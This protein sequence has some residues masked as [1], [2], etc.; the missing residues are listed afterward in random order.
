MRDKHDRIRY[1]DRLKKMIKVKGLQVAAIEVEDILLEHPD[2][3]LCDACVSGVNNG[4]G[5]GS[6]FVRAWAV[7]TNE[8]SSQAETVIARKLD[9][10][11]RNRL[12]KHK[13]LTGGIE[14][15]DS[16]SSTK[17]TVRTI[18]ILIRRYPEHHVERCCG[19]K[20]E[21][22]ITLI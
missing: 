15:V 13:W 7:L 11:V 3:L 20:C 10:W 5:D 6:L 22:N 19:A 17:T 16:V 8:E 14:V 1:L 21:T 2:V 4:R 18:L 12:S 9:E